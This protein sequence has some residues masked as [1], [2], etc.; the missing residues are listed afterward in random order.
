M[1][2]RRQNQDD[3]RFFAIFVAKSMLYVRE[4]SRH[5]PSFHPLQ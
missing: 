2:F 5:S 1:H 3:T 4:D